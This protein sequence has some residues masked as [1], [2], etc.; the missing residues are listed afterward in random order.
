MREVVERLAGLR[1]LPVVSVDD[2]ATAARA[3]RALARGG[4]ACLEITFRTPAAA[5]AIAA[6][7]AVD[8]LLVGAGTVL[9]PEQ[10][11]QAV[12]AGAHFAVAPGLDEAVVDRCRE[13]GLPFFPGVA[14][15]TEIQRAR[16]LGVRTLKVFPIAALGG[17]GFLRAVSAT[18]PDV[19]FIPTGGVG[20]GTLR[21]YLDVPSVLACG[22]SWLADGAALR[23]GRYE[24]IERRAREARELG[25]AGA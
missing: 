15:P 18:Y 19:R 6:A 8:G 16:T 12:D 10:V 2:G 22:G 7:R 20:P 14:T 25:G 5:A 17:P 3:G 23:D 4:V 21:E 13:R 24:D 9:S 11:D 1:V